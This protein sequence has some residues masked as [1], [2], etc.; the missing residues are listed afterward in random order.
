[1]ELCSAVFKL[2]NV[3]RHQKENR[4]I[5]CKCAL[6]MCQNK[7]SRDM[8]AFWRKEINETYQFCKHA[9]YIHWK[10]CLIYIPPWSD[11]L[12]Y[13][14]NHQQPKRSDIPVYMV[15]FFSARFYPFGTDLLCMELPKITRKINSQLWHL[16]THAVKQLFL[17]TSKGKNSCNWFTFLMLILRPVR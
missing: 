12:P 6:W 11:C 13:W 4:P 7:P 14:K 17:H 5:F 16:I 2:L 3:E 1:M 9:E 15:L 10:Y 8:V